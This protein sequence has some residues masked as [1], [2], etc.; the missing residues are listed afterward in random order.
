MSRILACTV[1]L[2]LAWI[3]VCADDYQ[4]VALNQ[5]PKVVR[6]AVMKRFPDAKPQEAHQGTDDNKKSFIDVHVLVKNQKV[7]ITCELD[8]TI[9]TVDREITLQEVPKPVAAAIQKRYPKAA[10]R[11][12]N[13]ITEGATPTYDVALTLNK[14]KLIATF[15]AAGEWLE[16]VEDDS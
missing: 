10:V 12:V 14:K 3:A 9:R 15:S 16:E 11:L 1:V 8:G 13:E 2:S 6:D 5:V 4:P 7:W